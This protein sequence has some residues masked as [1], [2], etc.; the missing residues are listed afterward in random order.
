MQSTGVL[1]ESISMSFIVKFA[2]AS[3]AIASRCSTVFV[4]PPM[5]MSRV[6]ALSIA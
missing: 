1:R 5:A 6:M 2:P 3:L 4:L